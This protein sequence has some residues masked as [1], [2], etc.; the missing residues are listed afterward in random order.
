MKGHTTLE[1]GGP[2]SIRVLNRLFRHHIDFQESDARGGVDAG[3]VD[4]VDAGFERDEE[5]GVRA[6]VGI[7]GERAHRV[8]GRL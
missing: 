1:K 2:I 7:E 6:V 8:E 5:R 4:G 3:E